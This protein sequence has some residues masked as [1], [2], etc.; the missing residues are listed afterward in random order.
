MIRQGRGLFVCRA[1]AA[2]VTSSAAPSE[3]PSL[4]QMKFF[5]SS[6]RLRPEAETEKRAVSEIA[7]RSMTYCLLS[8]TLGCGCDRLEQ[9]PGG[10]CTRFRRGTCAR[11][12]SLHETD[13]ITAIAMVSIIGVDTMLPARSAISA[14]EV[15]AISS[16]SDG[17]WLGKTLE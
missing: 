1:A 2:I 8:L 5:D 9:S 15:F 17:S 7:T 6:F 11:G 3:P 4:L 10:E 12:L 14:P 16:E 13:E